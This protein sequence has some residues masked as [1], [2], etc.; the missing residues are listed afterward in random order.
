MEFPDFR[1]LRSSQEHE[2]DRF[3][4]YYSVQKRKVEEIYKDRK[5]ELSKVHTNIKDDLCAMVRILCSSA[6]FL[7]Y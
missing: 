5:N 3:L 6:A 4:D 1:S 2:R 7:V